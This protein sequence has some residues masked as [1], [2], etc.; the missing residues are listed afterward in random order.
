ME[1]SKLCSKDVTSNECPVGLGIHS[2]A[3]TPAGR[4]AFHPAYNKTSNYY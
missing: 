3:R 2:A 4:R 1:T